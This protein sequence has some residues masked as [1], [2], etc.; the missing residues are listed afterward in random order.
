[1]ND[2]QAFQKYLAEL[3]IEDGKGIMCELDERLE[4][5]STQIFTHDETMYDIARNL[6]ADKRNFIRLDRFNNDSLFWY[7][8]ET[9]K[10]YF[11]KKTRCTIDYYKRRKNIDL[12]KVMEDFKKLQSGDWFEA[13]EIGNKKSSEYLS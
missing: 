11:D 10:C 2:Q 12:K 13:S 4:I 9:I 3:E 7:V 5:I 1:M 6:I 8:G